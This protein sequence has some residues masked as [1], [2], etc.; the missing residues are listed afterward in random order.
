MLNFILSWVEHGKIL[1]HRGKA[2]FQHSSCFSFAFSE[3]SCTRNSLKKPWIF[4]LYGILGRHPEVLWRLLSNRT[5]G[6]DWSLSGKSRWYFIK[7]R[8]RFLSCRWNIIAKLRG[9]LKMNSPPYYSRVYFVWWSTFCLTNGNVD[10]KRL[11]IF[12]TVSVLPI[13]QSF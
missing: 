11:T 13:Q 4:W 8:T 6:M 2:P 3:P 1:W 10:N 7:S 5:H 12:F 9:V